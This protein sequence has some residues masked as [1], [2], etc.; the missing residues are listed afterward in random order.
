MVVYIYGGGVSTDIKTVLDNW[1]NNL[2]QLYNKRNEAILLDNTYTDL[3]TNKEKLER[4]MSGPEYNENIYINEDILYNKENQVI[5]RL[6][7]NKAVSIDQISYEI[8]KYDDIKKAL[9]TFFNCCFSLGHLFGLSQSLC[10]YQKVPIR[11]PMCQ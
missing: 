1:Q 8:L 11:T 5:N 6:R 3:L 2:S 10:Q 4:D 7:C 9:I